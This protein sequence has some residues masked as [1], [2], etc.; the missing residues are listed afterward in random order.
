LEAT[1]RDRAEDLMAAFSD[2]SIR[3]MFAS[4]GGADRPTALAD[5][6]VTWN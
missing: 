6:E 1:W 3:A 2:S 5:P 4:I